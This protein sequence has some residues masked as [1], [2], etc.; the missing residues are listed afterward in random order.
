MNAHPL[1]AITDT[2]VDAFWRDG[3]ICLR[4]LFDAEWVEHVRAAVEDNLA[5][6]GPLAR[7]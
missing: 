5:R 4:G 3:V 7:E 6:L 1:A 2:Q